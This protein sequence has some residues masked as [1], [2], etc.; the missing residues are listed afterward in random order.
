MI[1]SDFF[2]DYIVSSL[3]LNF[4]V[5]S[6]A[7]VETNESHAYMLDVGGVSNPRFL[8]D[9]YVVKLYGLY[10]RSDYELGMED[11]NTLKD[12]ILGHPNI[13]DTDG[14]DW[15]LF[16]LRQ[17]PFFLSIDDIGRYVYTMEFEVTKDS[18]SG[19]HR[20]PIN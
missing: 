6:S 10:N 19:V 3:T 4:P 11:L 9:M 8:R 16:L 13:T 5:F 20:I 17:P 18:A 7:G 1:A 14:N 12:N 15:C 2:Y